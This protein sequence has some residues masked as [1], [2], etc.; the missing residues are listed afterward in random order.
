MKAI[1]NNKLDTTWIDSV[2][3]NDEN[4]TDEEL[5][6]YFRENGVPDDMIDELIRHRMHY[7]TEIGYSIFY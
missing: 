6:D 3:A 4:S 1:K 5:Q 2:M 7:L